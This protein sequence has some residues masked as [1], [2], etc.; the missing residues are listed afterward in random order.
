VLAGAVPISPQK[1]SAFF[2]PPPRDSLASHLSAVPVSS[3]LPPF[4]Q[5]GGGLCA[6]ILKSF[7]N[8]ALPIVYEVLCLR[9]MMTMKDYTPRPASHCPAMM[10][11]TTSVPLRRIMTG[12]NVLSIITRNLT[13]DSFIDAE[14]CHQATTTKHRTT[15]RVTCRPMMMISAA[16][17]RRIQKRR[18][19]TITMTLGARSYV[20]QSAKKG[21]T[22]IV[23]PLW[24]WWWRGHWQWQ[25]SGVVAAMVAAVAMAAVAAALVVSGG[26]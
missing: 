20:S 19:R 23:M 8:M 12:N 7:S 24:H 1:K 14:S 26:R 2:L 13:C 22:E 18:R 21:T 4:A 9:A 3:K 6:I 10:K 25:G 15:C 17:T 5:H 16:C 11:P